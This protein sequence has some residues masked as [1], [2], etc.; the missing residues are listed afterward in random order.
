MSLES[1]CRDRRVVVLHPSALAY[2]AGRALEDNGVGAVL[3]QERGQLL[4]VVTDRDLALRVAGPGLDPTEVEIGEVMSVDVAALPV[5]GTVQEAIELMLRRAIRR[6]PV[7]RGEQVVGLVTLDDLI[8]HA[9][10]DLDTLARIVRAQLSEPSRSKGVNLIH[11]MRTPREARVKD[12]EERH[13]SRAESALHEFSKQLRDTLLLEDPQRALTAFEVVAAALVQRLTPAEAHDF[14]AQLPS[15]MRERLAGVP[16][17]PDVSVTRESLE[18][19]MAVR[20]DLDPERAAALVRRVAV[21][22]GDFVTEAEV[23]HVIAQLPRDM[24]EIFAPLA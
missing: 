8:L 1:Y 9:D 19:D 2:E 5:E 4:G 24:K 14:V 20:L 17:G 18:A 15:L 3:V 23:E 13:R 11:P 12:R 10:A 7:T 22:V 6:V 16:A 21:C